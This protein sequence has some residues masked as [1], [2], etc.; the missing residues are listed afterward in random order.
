MNAVIGM[1]S[2]LLDENLP[3]ELKGYLEI[4]RNGGWA[5]LSLISDLLDLSRIEN[6]RR[7]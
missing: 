7:T 1:T 5:M 6:P 3:P 2:R 4:I